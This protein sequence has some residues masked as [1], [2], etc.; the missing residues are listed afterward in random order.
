MGD[1]HRASIIVVLTTSLFGQSGR[2]EFK[3]PNGREF[4]SQ[5]DE[6]GVVAEAQKVLAASPNDIKLILKLSLAHAVV[7]EDKEAVAACTRGPAID[8]VNVGLLVERGHRELPL[9]MFSEARA[10][11]KR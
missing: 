1:L 9:R 10:D 7:W 11:L 8:P 4:Q 6:K 3:S 2:V 5:P